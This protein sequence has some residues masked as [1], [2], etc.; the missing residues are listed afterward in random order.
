MNYLTPVGLAVLCALGSCQVL[1]QQ[2]LSRAGHPLVEQ[3]KIADQYIVVF[4]KN[5]PGLPSL[6]QQQQWTQ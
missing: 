5:T 2:Q 4:H 6:Q 3:S 1:A